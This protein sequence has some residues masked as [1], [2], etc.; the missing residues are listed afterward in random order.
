[1]NR[2]AEGPAPDC[3]PRARRMLT[4]MTLLAVAMAV[5]NIMMVDLSSVRELVNPL[6]LAFVPLVLLQMI[7]RGRNWARFVLAAY[8]LFIMWNNRMGF[9]ATRELMQ[10]A[11]YAQ[12]GFYV[13]VFVG[14]GAI[15]AAATFAKSIGEMLDY[16]AEQAVAQDS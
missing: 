4:G 8:C 11:E 15:A 6:M 10:D 12:A 13:L 1:M 3:L 7:W 9:A 5:W 2:Q 14:H 16:R